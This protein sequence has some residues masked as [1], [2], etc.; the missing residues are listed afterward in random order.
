[1]PGLLAGPPMGLLRLPAKAN[2]VSAE[3]CRA[4]TGFDIYLTFAQI[5]SHTLSLLSS[6]NVGDLVSDP[7]K[8][9]GKIIVLYILIFKFL[10]SKLKRKYSSPNDSK[11][12][13]FNLHCISSKI[14]FSF[15]KFIPNCLNSSTLSKEL[16]LI[17]IK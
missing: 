6:L 16:L 4:C 7:Y 2:I 17:F 15:V 12:S 10:D 13:D 9:T 5:F 3:K 14:E 8:T 11:H 1:M